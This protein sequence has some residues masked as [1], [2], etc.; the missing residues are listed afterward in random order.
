VNSVLKQRVITACVLVLVLALVLIVL[1]FNGFLEAISLL[2]VIA[3]WEWA[4]MAG[5]SK[6]WQRFIYAGAFAVLFFALM[7]L[8]LQQWTAAITSVLFFSVFGWLLALFAVWRY[9]E[10]KGWQQTW[11]LLLIGLW[12]LVPAWLGLQ[13]LQPAVARSGLIWLVIAVIAAADIGAYF[14][15]RRFGRRKLAVHVSPGKTWEGFWGGVLANVLLATIIALFLDLSVVKFFGF[16]VAMV[17]VAAMSVLGDLFES[18]IKRE[19]GIKDSSQLLPGH[20]GVL[21]RIDG[22]TAAV[23]L[24]A[25]FYLL[26]GS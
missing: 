10:N 11:L 16:V 19:R 18:M 24:F 22:W 4:N 3:A 7:H 17:L 26:C 2:L 13:L 5:L 1:P 25:L 21:D 9:P 8:D 6:S 20:G 23:P 12:L 14:S 15:G